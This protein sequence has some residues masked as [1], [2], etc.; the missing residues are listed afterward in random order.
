LD[1]LLQ[2]EQLRLAVGAFIDG[3]LSGK[4]EWERRRSAFPCM[5]LGSALLRIAVLRRHLIV[6]A[7][8]AEWGN[9]GVNAHKKT[10]QG[11]KGETKL[12]A[13]FLSMGKDG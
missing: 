8:I 4:A 3:G 1:L 5:K 11:E 6:T 12:A 7:L 10:L 9:N 13:G 2:I